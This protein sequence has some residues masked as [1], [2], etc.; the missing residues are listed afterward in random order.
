[1]K[2]QTLDEWLD[3]V[4]YT[5]LNS[6]NYVPST[7]SLEFLNFIK[8]CN[9]AQGESN[10][11]P[12]MHLRMLDRLVERECNQVVNVVHRGGAKTTLFSEYL[13]LYCAVFGELPSLGDVDVMLYIADSV[14]NGAKSLRK[15]IEHRYRNSEFLQKVL[16]EDKA[17]FTDSYIEFTNIDGKR[18]ALKLYGATSGLRG[19]K[20]FGKRPQ[21]VIIDDVMSDEAAK[22][23]ATLALIKDTIYNGVLNAVDP[24]RHLIIF[25]GT[26]FNKEDV[27]VEA[28]ESGA[29]DVSVYPVCEKF[30]CTKEE[31]KGS[32]PDRFTYEFIQTRYNLA[33]NTGKKASFYQELMLRISPEEERVISEGDIR[34]YKRNSILNHKEYYNFYITTDF[35]T[36]NKTSADYSVILVWAYNAKGQWFLVDGCCEQSLMDKNLDNLFKFASMYRPQEVGIEVTGQQGGFIQ[37]AQER[38]M[39]R[40]IWFNFST[41]NNGNRPGIRPIVDKYSRFSLVVPWFKTGLIYFPVDYKENFFIKELLNELYL[42]TI[43]GIKS[44]HDD[45][46]DAVSMLSYL[47]AWKPSESVFFNKNENDIWET[48]TTN[49]DI[50]DTIGLYIV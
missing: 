28:V 34:W 33:V 47:K 48:S 27:I 43:N 44:K 41:N 46:L 11:T 1:M 5:Y 35:A 2:K 3:E 18:F 38:M 10:K 29:W 39:D 36:S 40:N 7:F 32:W 30:P 21:L 6:S 16:P 50:P 45:C 14:D 23:K 25:N 15:N 49:V 13:P 8:L 9:G 17:I 26:P 4:D 42:V 22:S 37:W 31:F 19:V 20:V 12:T 24:T